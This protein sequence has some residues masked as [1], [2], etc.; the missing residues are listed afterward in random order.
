MNINPTAVQAIAV[1]EQIGLA[2]GDVATDIE[3]VPPVGDFETRRNDS[4]AAADGDSIIPDPVAVSH[5]L[6]PLDPDAVIAAPNLPLLVANLDDNMNNAVIVHGYTI[7]GI[8]DIAQHVKRHA[9][10]FL[11]PACTSIFRSFTIMAPH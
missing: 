4:V 3:A 7:E 2:A 10:A 9:I 8:V 11:Q 6:P 5:D 1:A